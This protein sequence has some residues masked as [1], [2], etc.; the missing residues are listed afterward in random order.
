MVS[1]QLMQQLKIERD[2]SSKKA[3]VYEKALEVISNAFDPKTQKTLDRQDMIDY[4]ANA[5]KPTK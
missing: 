4:A 3:Y 1:Q 5:I 2:K